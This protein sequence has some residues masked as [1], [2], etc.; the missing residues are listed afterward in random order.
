MS[1]INEI[2]GSS[3]KQ[4]QASCQEVEQGPALTKPLSMSAVPTGASLGQTDATFQQPRGDEL[5][6][7]R[8]DI[9]TSGQAL[10][11]D[12]TLPGSHCHPFSPWGG[13]LSPMFQPELPWETRKGSEEASVERC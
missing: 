5:F 1:H 3:Q 7:H 4:L 2:K 9:Q 10:S 8:Q 6:P 13:C 12:A 11:H